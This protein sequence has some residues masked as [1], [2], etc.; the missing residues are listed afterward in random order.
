MYTDG[1]WTSLR[2]WKQSADDTGDAH[3]IIANIPNGGNVGIGVDD[4]HSQLTL[5]N[6]MAVGAN[7]DPSTSES[8]YAPPEKS[9]FIQ[10]RLIVANNTTDSINVADPFAIQAA[11]NI[12]TRNGKI[13]ESGNDLIPR[14][15]IVMW[16]GSTTDVPA[17]W[18][19]CDG[20]NDTPNLSG[21][22]ILA[23]GERKLVIKT[24]SG[25]FQE[26]GALTSFDP[27]LD[28]DG[29]YTGP[30]LTHGADSV[31]LS[32]NEM[33]EHDHGGGTHRH[34]VS[35]P[36]HKNGNPDDP[37]ATCDTYNECAHFYRHYWVGDNGDIEL[38]SGAKSMDG[39]ND[40]VIVMDQGSDYFHENR[41][42]Y[43]VL[44]YIM[45]L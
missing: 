5:A 27:E 39:S 23:A 13:Q 14:G 25:D 6:N 19:M 35:A 26:F 30:N 18:A 40:A 8:A 21:R 31:Q 24:N 38:S 3:A 22:F 17:G 37:S 9:L 10:N 28:I 45:K 33:P 2:P 29:N 16:H 34:T 11:G 20:T 36:I 15:V 7:P 32:V 42:P 1:E 44:C 43:Y 4:P 41:P 12:D